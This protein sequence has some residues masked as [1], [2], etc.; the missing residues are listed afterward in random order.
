MIYG[1]VGETVFTSIT[2]FITFSF[3][4]G[5]GNVTSYFVA[6]VIFPLFNADCLPLAKK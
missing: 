6:E 4:T 2:A 3:P 1:L 5:K